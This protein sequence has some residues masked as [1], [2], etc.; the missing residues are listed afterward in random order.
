MVGASAVDEH[1]GRGHV[2]RN[3]GGEHKSHTREDSSFPM[4]RIG[5][6]SERSSR[7]TGSC[8]TPA[9]IRLAMAPGAMH[10]TRTL[11]SAVSCAK[12]LR[13]HREASSARGTCAILAPSDGLVHTRHVNDNAGLLRDHQFELLVR[14]QEGA[15]EIGLNHLSPGMD[16]RFTGRCPWAFDACVIDRHID[17]ASNLV[18]GW[19]HVE[20]LRQVR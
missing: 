6:F 3:I 18:R 12:R 10:S 11:K 20:R 8:R 5:T 19:G 17:A 4:R 9:L 7:P 16:I 15:Q 1:R 2:A 13:G 14:A